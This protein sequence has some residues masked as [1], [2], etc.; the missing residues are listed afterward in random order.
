MKKLKGK[1]TRRITDILSA[2]VLWCDGRGC[3]KVSTQYQFSF[4]DNFFLDITKG[5]GIVFSYHV[6]LKER[7]WAVLDTTL[8]YDIFRKDVPIQ[9]AYTAKGI[10]VSEGI[11]NITG[12][13]N[14]LGKLNEEIRKKS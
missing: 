6:I 8:D 5:S 3:F 7:G 9:K 13:K 10:R 14:L 4:S 11:D 1:L 2:L 12:L